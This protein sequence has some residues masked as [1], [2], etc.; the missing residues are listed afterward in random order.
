M[1]ANVAAPGSLTLPL[2]QT[3]SEILGFDLLEV[4]R[5][6]PAERLDATNFSQPAIFVTSVAAAEQLRQQKPAVVEGC[7]A[8]AGL[9][10]GEYTALWFAGVFDFETGV[11]LVAARGAAMQMASELVPS[12]MVSILGLELPQ[13]EEVCRAA[14]QGEVLQVANLLCPGNTAISGHRGACERGVEAA[15]KAGGK[16]IPLS[17]AGAFHTPIM[18][19]A[20]KEFNKTLSQAAFSKPR[21]PVISNVDA[22]THDDPEQIKDLL[23]EQICSRV[24]WENSVRLLLEQGF[25]D[26]Y[27]V[28]P[29]RVLTGLIRRIDRKINCQTT[30]G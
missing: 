22:A 26:L 27:E 20:V 24:L 6:G 10:L 17:V 18:E 2:F 29:G 23:L 19:P 7:Q 28:G 21:I 3:A 12:G 11:R 9:S 8:A 30:L 1:A 16:A 5:Q 4:C 15:E 13:V 25:D 14:S